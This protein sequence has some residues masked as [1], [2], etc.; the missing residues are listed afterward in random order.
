MTM[1][2]QRRFAITNTRQFLRDLLDPKL[3]P[4]VPR[5]VR[6][7]AS[8]ELKHYPTEFDM[9]DVQAAFGKADEYQRLNEGPKSQ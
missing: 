3:T 8:R 1:P 5:S 7:R 6:K 9:D 4:R 2:Y